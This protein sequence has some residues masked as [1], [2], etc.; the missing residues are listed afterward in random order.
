L[1]T[2]ETEVITSDLQNNEIIQTIDVSQ[3]S[4]KRELRFG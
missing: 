1:E 3:P 4:P 2:I